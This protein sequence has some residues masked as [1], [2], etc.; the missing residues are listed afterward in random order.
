MTPETPGPGEPALE[1]T[2][3][4]VHQGGVEVLEIPRFSL[5]AGSVLALI[6]PNGSGK[7][8]LLKT[9]ACLQAPASGRLRFQGRALA[10]R[11]ER[12]AYRQRV[13]MV[14]SRVS[15]QAQIHSGTKAVHGLP[16]ASH[17][18]PQRVGITIAQ[19]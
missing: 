3:L 9:L 12:E 18:A 5:A 8:T 7:T 11:Q 6:G 16:V 4:V 13:T 15:V 1:A 17:S 2:D 14:P 19:V 10:T